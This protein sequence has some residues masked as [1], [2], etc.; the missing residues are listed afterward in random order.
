MEQYF[1]Y[2]NVFENVQIFFPD[3][4]F[5]QHFKMLIKTKS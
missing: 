3:R 4:E 1:V 5:W 2:V